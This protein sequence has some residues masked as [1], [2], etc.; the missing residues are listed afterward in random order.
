MEEKLSGPSKHPYDKTTNL[1]AWYKLCTANFSRIHASNDKKV[2][3][4]YFNSL[5]E[6][7]Y[8]ELATRAIDD[9]RY[10]ESLLHP[11]KKPYQG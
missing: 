11:F 7:L 9:A 4:S 5:T 8:I 2:I 1:L 10:M 3:D 6:N